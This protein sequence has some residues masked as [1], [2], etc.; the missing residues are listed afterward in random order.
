MAMNICIIGAGAVGCLLG[1]RLAAR[2]GCAPS[3]LARGAALQALRLH[4]WRG[5]LD[6]GRLAAP[7]RVVE[8]AEDL[9]PQVD[10]LLGL[11]RLMAR[12]RGLYPWPAAGDAAAA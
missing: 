1:T 9:G 4:G 11:V 3:V 5:D 12:V 6:D 2:G 7:A 10:A 8:Q